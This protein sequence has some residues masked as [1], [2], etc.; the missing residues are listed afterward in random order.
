MRPPLASTTRARPSRIA[1]AQLWGKYAVILEDRPKKLI[2]SARRVE[3]CH[4][5]V[6][7]TRDMQ[8]RI[9]VEVAAKGGD[10]G[11]G[12]AGVAAGEGGAADPAP[13]RPSEPPPDEPDDAPPYGLSGRSP[14]GV[15]VPDMTGIVLPPQMSMLASMMPAVQETLLPEGT[16][17]ARS[18]SRARRAR[19]ARDARARARRR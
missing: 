14:V 15:R 5:G 10:E 8:E 13:P 3:R 11:S 18:P 17:Q 4:D 6:I 9:D 7:P 2:V 1:H 16:E 19:A 12:E